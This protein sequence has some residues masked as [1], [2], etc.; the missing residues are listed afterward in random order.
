MKLIEKLRESTKAQHAKLDQIS[1]M[2]QLTSSSVGVDD[3]KDYLLAFRNIY[4]TIEKDIYDYSSHYLKGITLNQRLPYLKSDLEQFDVG[5]QTVK[6][7]QKLDLSN[8]EYLGALYVMEGSRLGGAMIGRH[9]EKQ[10]DYDK[11]NLAFLFSSPAIKWAQIISFLNEQADEN[12]VQ[13]TKGA[14][15]VFKYFYDELF[16]FYKGNK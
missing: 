1:E 14:Q 8:H 12:H 3:Y 10:L 4:S 16:E 9:L 11:N 5:S 15:K 13:I 2:N 7:T 6:E